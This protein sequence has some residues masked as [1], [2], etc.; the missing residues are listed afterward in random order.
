MVETLGKYTKFGAKP[1]IVAKITDLSE[2]IKGI[3]KPSNATEVPSAEAGLRATEPQ[4]APTEKG[5]G[6]SSLKAQ[7]EVAGVKPFEEPKPSAAL[8]SAERKTTPPV[9]PRVARAEAIGAKKIERVGEPPPEPLL[10]AVVDKLREA[11]QQ[12]YESVREGALTPGS[13][14]VVLGSL[15]I[16]GSWIGHNVGYAIP[17]TA[18]RFGEA[19]LVRSELGRSWLTKITPKDIRTIQK[20]LEKAPEDKPAVTVAITKGLIDKAQRGEQLPLPLRAFKGLL[21]EAQLGSI[22]RVIAP[23]QG[24]GKK[25]PRDAEAAA[26]AGIDTV[27]GAAKSVWQATAIP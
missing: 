4:P 6:G 13:H 19:A 15:S 22:L 21:T 3:A 5:K 16:A 8:A 14:D 25:N 1:A 26:G 2:Q 23:P 17:Y 9:E 11:K 24:S 7:L 27:K 10:D 12:A 18:L 20:V